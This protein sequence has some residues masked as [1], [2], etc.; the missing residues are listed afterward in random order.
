MQPNPL[1]VISLCSLLLG[2]FFLA[3]SISTKTPKYVLH[4]L[5][6]FKV[7]KSRFFRKHISQKLDSIIGFA[8]LFVGFALQIYLEVEALKSL[9]TPG[10]ESAIT[11]WW[12][13]GIG[14]ATVLGAIVYL[15]S[16]ITRYFSGK[17]FVEMVRFMVERH[18]YPLG[19]DESLV[20]EVGRIMRIRRDEED[21]IESYTERVRAKMKLPPGK[22]RKGPLSYT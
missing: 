8:F 15:L 16:R 6:S 3:K 1:R 7:N 22:G 14:M 21:T 12:Y 9:Q 10:E 13:L 11:N 2:S 19:G 17:I 18:G 20:L 4:E 5:L